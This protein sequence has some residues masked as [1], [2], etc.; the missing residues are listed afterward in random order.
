V[1]D[2][3][4]YRDKKITWEQLLEAIKANFKG[5][6]PIRQLCING[7]PKYGNEND[8]ADGWAS[9]VMDTWYDNVDWINTQKDLLPYYGGTYTGATIIGQTNV[10]F[11]PLIGTLPNGR[12]HP[13]PLADCISP[14]PGADR[15]GPTAVI[16][17]VSK[18]PT[19]RFAM[20]GVLNL[21]LSPQ[22]VATDRDLENFVSF[23]RAIE[24]LGIYHTQFNVVSSDLLRKAMKEPE[25]YR[26]L[27][28][29]VASYCTYFNELTEEQ[30]LD[31]INRTEHQGW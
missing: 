17:S 21:R 3:L 2:K 6:E 24:E 28:V 8:F 19:H 31:I 4:I 7:V 1:I 16:K 30:K 29:R 23:L 13:K 14:F 11:G 18:L 10:T 12:I 26:D 5:Y 20:G 27:L 25:N 22:L 9:W 15:N